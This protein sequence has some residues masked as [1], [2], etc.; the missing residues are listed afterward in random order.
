MS[1]IGTERQ[2]RVCPLEVILEVFGAILDGAGPRWAPDGMSLDDVALAGGAGASPTLVHVVSPQP[3]VARG[4]A[5]TI[6]ELGRTVRVTSGPLGRAEMPAVVVYDVI[7]LL[8]DGGRALDAVLALP[9]VG[10]L[11]VGRELRPELEIRALERGAHHSVRLGAAPAELV[12]GVRL[13]IGGHR[14]RRV[15]SSSSLQEALARRAGVTPREFEVL[16]RVATMSTNDEIARALCISINSVKT[17]IRTAYR[18]LGVTTRSQAVTWC[19]LNGFEP[20]DLD[21]VLLPLVRPKHRGSGGE[22]PGCA[23]TRRAG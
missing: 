9:Q 16:T 17:Y 2:F 1:N 3:M 15:P 20:G 19:L 14:G 13:L 18:K 4:I 7:G 21:Q 23:P 22:D 8:D 11:A 10:V 5:S 6:G 12:A